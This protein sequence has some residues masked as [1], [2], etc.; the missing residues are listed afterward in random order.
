MKLLDQNFFLG[1]LFAFFP[2]LLSSLNF[3]VLP[4]FHSS[5]S[6]QFPEQV[7][8]PFLQ[9]RGGTLQFQAAEVNAALPWRVELLLAIKD[10]EQLPT[11]VNYCRI[12]TAPS[13]I[14]E[15]VEF[16]QSNIGVFLRLCCSCWSLGVPKTTRTSPLVFPGK[17]TFISSSFHPV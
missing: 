3:F 11:N 14:P 16:Q 5:L 15:E 9:G 8:V 6:L 10:S 7:P 12:I 13:L 17:K 4:P 2:L 1:S